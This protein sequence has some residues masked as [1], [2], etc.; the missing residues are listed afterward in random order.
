MTV[1]WWTLGFQTVNVAILIWLL[2]R[3]FWKPVAGMI[4]AR[5]AATQQLTDE[6]SAAQSKATAALADNE[7]TRAGF[8]KERETILADA[9]K[10]AEAAYA[11]RL[12]QAETDAAALGAAAK[13][14][15]SKAEKAQSAAWADRS[16]ELAVAIAQRLAARLN[17]AIVEACFLDW[18][19]AEIE[20]LPKT[21]AGK[22]NA[23]TLD[24]TTATSPD[25]A[26][27]TAI[28]AAIGA[29]LGGTPHITFK[30]DPA[31]IAGIEL[32]GDH[33][34]VNSSWRAD[35]GIIRAGLSV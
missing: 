11:A 24:A 17:S 8:A 9:H 5:Q 15:S 28:V 31:L 4:A 23:V 3:F 26:A 2:G 6:A 10:A 21:A 32:R 1:D 16:S 35:L 22:T 25:A 18:L 29:A 20:K 12:A 7:K 33:V 30:T 14:K 27:Q 34:I 19:V 13:E